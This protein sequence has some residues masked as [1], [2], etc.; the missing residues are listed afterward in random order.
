MLCALSALGALLVASHPASADE[1]PFASIYTTEP[2]P[3]GAMEVEQ[4]VT[5][6]HKKAQ[7]QFDQVEART[8]IEYGISNRF[9][10][11]LYANYEH[12]KIEPEGPGAP[13]GAFDATKFTRFNA[14]FIY[15]V[16]DP[17]TKPIGFAL[18]FE[19]G[20]GD[21][22]RSL[23]FKLLVQKNFLDDRV[24]FAANFNLEYE[25]QHDDTL[26]IWQRAS[27]FEIYLGASYR[28]A[29]GW[30]A[31]VEFLNENAYEGHIFSGAHAAENAF[32][33]GPTLHYAAPS[34]WATLGVF[35]QLPWAGNP[36]EASR[37]I[38][39][40]YLVDA[41]RIRLRLRIGVQL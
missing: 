8:E 5:W 10:A 29:P 32:Y 22:A 38:S 4:W 13:D 16:L 41:E 39:H 23:E 17:Y 1:S 14:E 26:D 30:F 24:I 15:Q 21:G 20:I 18:Y 33:F 11:S 40:G 35:A 27:A 19:P 9:L 7:E 31:G 34:W 12:T 3:K 37:A 28:F 2:L 6:K 25:W 36:A